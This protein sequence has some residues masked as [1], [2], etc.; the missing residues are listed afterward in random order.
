[1]NLQDLKYGLKNLIKWFK[2]IWKDRDWDHYYLE[3]MMLKKL[4]G[5][6]GSIENNNNIIKGNGKYVDYYRALNICIEILERRTSEFYNELMYKDINVDVAYEKRLM[7]INGKLEYTTNPDYDP[8]QGTLLRSQ[9]Q[10]VY[11]IELR[12]QK[13][14][15]KLIGTYLS[16]WLD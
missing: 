15:G 13:V 16:N 2:T 8:K 6:R 7:I 5:M 11:S 12:D 10:S 3:V 14:L 4:K 1:M 9:I